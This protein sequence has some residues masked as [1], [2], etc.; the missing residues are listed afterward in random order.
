[1][2]EMTDSHIVDKNQ[3]CPECGSSDAL[4]VYSDG[5]AF[6]YSC[7]HNF[8][9]YHAHIEKEGTTVLGTEK[10]TSAKDT[11]FVPMLSFEAIQELEHK[12]FRERA[13]DKRVTSFFGVRSAVSS[14]GTVTDHYYPYTSAGELVAFKKREVATKS[15]SVVGSF[16]KPELFGQ[17]CFKEGG[18]RV[19]LT[20]GE[21]DAMA[22]AQACLTE[23][24][25]IYPVVSMPSATGIKAVKNNRSWLR[26]FD[27]VILWLDNDEAGENGLKQV[28]KAIGFD[29]VKV[30]KGLEKDANDVLLKHGSKEA[31]RHVWDAKPYS[32][33][34]IISDPE[35]LWEQLEEYNN[36]VSVP[37]PD[38][39]TGL[40]EK[41]KGMRPG[42]ITL[43][44]SGTGSGKSTLLREIMLHLL[45]TTD[46]KIGLVSLEEAPAETAR[47]LAGMA[48]N[49]NPVKEPIAMD[50]LRVGFDKVFTDNRCIVLDHHGAIND[51]SITDT[52]EA[53]CVMG[54]KYLFV[55]HITILVSEGDEGLTGN[56]AIDKVMNNLLSIAKRHNVWIGLVSHLR[57]MTTAGSSFEDGKL[58]SL[59]DIRGSGSIKQISFDILA[60]SRNLTAASEAERNTINMAVLK[61]R[62]TGLTGN[63]GTAVYN[64]DTGRLAYGG[65]APEVGGAAGVFDIEI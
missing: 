49:K 27:E 40:N 37:Y 44:T 62:Y 38:C 23:S 47:K 58:A 7:N 21:C 36:V 46:D 64:Y 13:I 52:L 63:C 56:E 43:W 11:V 42:E 59:D 31:M 60:F 53:M 17:S 10:Q 57:K 55:D 34:G 12:G 18:K 9:D 26:A 5:H 19:V 51:G 29:K 48:I 61:S 3:P 4:Q 54:A 22:Y 15:F 65:F 30:V 14:E 6:C 32:P 2:S 39:L 16:D 24:G 50:E 8:K 25:Q 41:V 20:E 45:E 35:V 1:M 33:A 28:A